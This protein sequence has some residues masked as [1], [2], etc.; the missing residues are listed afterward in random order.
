MMYHQGMMIPMQV[1]KEIEWDAEDPEDDE[2][3]LD[4]ETLASCVQRW[5]RMGEIE[6]PAPGLSTAARFDYRR[7]LDPIRQEIEALLDEVWTE[8]VQE[9]AREAF[10]KARP[11]AARSWD[12]LAQRVAVAPTE[13]ADDGSGFLALPVVHESTADD[14]EVED[15]PR[16][17]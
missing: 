16:A 12:L 11:D 2:A 13:K 7:K 6:P 8:S 4:D 3:K 14:M 15:A 10:I 1:Q 5:G 17:S 9:L